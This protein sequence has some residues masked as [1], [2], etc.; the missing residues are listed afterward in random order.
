[1]FLLPFVEVNPSMV[2]AIRMPMMGNTM[3]SGLL[4]EWRVG[5][6]EEVEADDVV[7]VV[8]S[9]KAAADVVADRD[10]VVARVDV[11]EGEEVA[12]GTLL[13]V[14]VGENDE[15]SEA[16]PPRSRIEPGGENAA[17]DPTAGSDDGPSKAD[18]TDSEEA[19]SE[20][21]SDRPAEVPAAP[22]ARSLAAEHDVDLAAVEGTGPD[23]AVIIADVEDYVAAPDVDTG[24]EADESDGT[25]RVFATPS[26]RRLARDLGVSIDEVV[27]SGVDERITESDVR[28][29]AEDAGRVL[30]RSVELARTDAAAENGEQRRRNPG[31]FGVTIEE[32]RNLSPMRRTIAE[33]MSRSARE[34]PHVTNKREISAERALE[35]TDT[36]SEELGTTIGFTDVLVAAVA[37]ALATHPEFNAWYEGER[38]RLIAERNVA[39]AVDTDAGLVT[40]VIRST[41]DR[42][43]RSIASERRRLTDSVLDGEYTMGDLQGGTFT[44]TNLGMFGVDSFDPIINPPQ[45]GILGV[46]RIREGDDERTCVL[47]LSFDHRA[48]DGADAARFLDTIA[49][50]VES[51]VVI[52]T[53]G[54]GADDEAAERSPVRSDMPTAGSGRDAI[55]SA[56]GADLRE[57]A[58]EISAVH[59]WEIPDFA[60]RLDDAGLSITVD[61]PEG[62]S[63]AT[64]R[65]LAYAACR[66]SSYRASIGGL[67]D[68]EITLA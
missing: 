41:G 12:P 68:P 20:T 33:R 22:G 48:V 54:S 3:E 29:A 45:V 34:A 64:M 56:I 44:I 55:E 67:T 17:A 50:G 62:A 18:G 24:S 30:D 31:D 7:A 28:A 13:G 14:I 9:E 10:G 59:G 4:D 40:P 39:I 21:G 47:S 65:R 11:E 61:A 57:Q 52:R 1:M 16:P 26:T 2:Q 63:P 8:E 6:G 25:T 53:A 58:R 43:L 51:P 46:G 19:G 42:S 15:L 32:E 37:R 66:E 23:G 5:E 35:A 38:M 60:V 36:L 49:E 27:G